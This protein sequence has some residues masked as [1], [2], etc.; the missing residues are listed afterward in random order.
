MARKRESRVFRNA[1]IL[2][3]KQA[4]ARSFSG[5]NFNPFF[6]ALMGMV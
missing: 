6:F 4:H 3:S 5:A 2:P 1:P